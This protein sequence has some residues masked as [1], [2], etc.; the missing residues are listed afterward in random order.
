M[1]TQ[2]FYIKQHDTLPAF[3]AV[4]TDNGTPISLGAAMG[5]KL[6]LKKLST[7]IVNAAMVIDP[8]QVANKGKVTYQW[9]SADTSVSG[10][11]TGEIQVT[12]GDGNVQTFPAG[13]PTATDAKYFYVEVVP[14]LGS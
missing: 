11:L 12:W 2:T 4:L 3:E 14:E 9:V 6:I 10:K 1:A 8:D 7:V 13:G 5:V